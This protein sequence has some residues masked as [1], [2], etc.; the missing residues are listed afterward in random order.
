MT[1]SPKG[2]AA[3]AVVT[4]LAVETLTGCGEDRADMAELAVTA[5]EATHSDTTYHF[6]LPAQVPAGATRV[7][8]SNAGDEPH[9]A[10]LFRLDGGK[11][12]EDLGAA[13]ATGDVTAT[14]EV[15]TFV[16][17]TGL[18]DPGEI[19]QADAVIQL[20][21]GNYAFICF[22]EG[23]DGTPHSAHG[24]LQPLTVTAATERSASAPDIDEE[25]SL[26][27]YAIDT[28][29]RLPGDATV[30]VTNDA[31][32]E[33]HELIVGRLHGDANVDDVRH[34]LEHGTPPP[35]TSVGGM[36]ALPPGTTQRLKLDLR[37]GRYVFI[38]H[39]TSPDGLAHYTKGMIKEVTIT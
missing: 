38:C 1:R 20:E 27:D 18:V 3:V 30:A 28:P 24:M 13:L 8:L 17:G 39:I 14:E 31:A 25:I 12:I 37:P 34:A 33:P 19:S 35:M 4:A 26:I 15:G 29:D 9:H 7:S 11:T 16:G 6:E 23:A 2:V 36:Q 22:V 21:E 10:Q 32:Q 5:T